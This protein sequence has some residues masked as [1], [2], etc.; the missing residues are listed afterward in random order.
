MIIKTFTCFWICIF[1]TANSFSQSK[2]NELTVDRP[3]VAETPFTVAKG[4]YQ[5]EVGFD[6]FKR[7][8]GELYN[9]PIVLFRTGIS[10]EAE[11]RISSKQI[12]DKTEVVPF[13]EISPLSVGVKHHVIKQRHGVPEV[14]ILANVIFPIG[15]SS[16]TKNIGPEFLLLFQNDFYPNTAI[17]YNVGYYWD[18]IR[19]KNYFTASFCFN[20]LPTENVGLF[21]EYF[22]Y[23]PDS[24]PG[25][26]GID[27]GFTYLL[28]PQFQVD[29]SAGVSHV[30]KGNNLFVS[31][32]FSFRL[33]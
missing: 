31:S 7:F 20:Y 6:Y 30:E 3:G 33:D 15:N 1:I 11:L 18:H 5:F 9:L 8:N 14:D 16:S 23:V 10:K 13:N 21:I 12:V 32:G 4:V 2:L 29:L 17:N 25:E 22:E 19:Q 24:W 28:G 27:G 26:V